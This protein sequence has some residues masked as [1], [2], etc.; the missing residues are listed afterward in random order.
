MIVI[1]NDDFLEKLRRPSNVV[2][3][4]SYTLDYISRS[5]VS[6]STV[7]EFSQ[8]VLSKTNPVLSGDNMI[9]FWD[10]DKYTF[11]IRL[12]FPDNIAFNPQTKEIVVK[13]TGGRDIS[14]SVI[15]FNEIRFYEDNGDL[16][17]VI[18]NN[19]QMD[20]LNSLLGQTRNL[21][22]IKFLDDSVAT[23][24][25]AKENNDFVF[26]S[27]RGVDLGENLFKVDKEGNIMITNDSYF[28]AFSLR[29]SS[30][31]VEA[32]P[33]VRN[34]APYIDMLGKKNSNDYTYRIYKNLSI[35]CSGLEHDCWVPTK[36]NLYRNYEDYY[37]KDSGIRIYGTADYDEYRVFGEEHNRVASG[38]ET[39][40]SIPGIE[41]EE[42]KNTGLIYT[43]DYNKQK[44]LYTKPDGDE[45][46]VNMNASV[47]LRAKLRNYNGEEIVSSQ[48][49]FFQGG[50]EDEWKLESKSTEYYEP[51]DKENI[52]VFL[53]QYDAGMFYTTK[54]SKKKDK[55][56]HHMKITTSLDI[57]KKTDITI[58]FENSLISKYFEV[59]WS[60]KRLYD[61]LDPTVFKK[62]E[63]YV[64][65][66]AKK[67][68]TDPV[69]WWPLNS[70]GVSTL[71]MATLKYDRYTIS[72][73][74]IQGPRVK[75]LKLYEFNP[76]GANFSE[77]R[78]IEFSA[79]EKTKTYWMMTEEKVIPSV[80]NWWKAT[81][82]KEE[83]TN[84]KLGISIKSEQYLGRDTYVTGKQDEIV[85]YP[86][87]GESERIGYGLFSEVS[88]MAMRADVETGTNT[89]SYLVSHDDEEIFPENKYLSILDEFSIDEN[90]YITLGTSKIVSQDG[91]VQ[92][93]FN[94]GLTSKI[95]GSFTELNSIPVTKSITTYINNT[96][97]GTTSD[98][99]AES[100]KVDNLK[101]NK[102]YT[103]TNATVPKSISTTTSTDSRLMNSEF[104]LGKGASKYW[105]SDSKVLGQF[106]SDTKDLKASDV[107]SAVGGSLLDKEY[108]SSRYYDTREKQD[109]AISYIAPD[110]SISYTSKE[111]GTSVKVV[112]D[113]EGKLIK[114]PRKIWNNMKLRPVIIDFTTSPKDVND[115]NGDP[116]TFFRVSKDELALDFNT[117][118][119][120]NM[121]T[122]AQVT[123]EISKKGQDP[124]IQI[125]EE[126]K[127]LD[128]KAWRFRNGRIEK[129]IQR[130]SSINI[131][132]TYIDRKRFLVRSNCPFKLTFKYNTG[133][134]NTLA[135][136]K[137]TSFMKEYTISN[138]SQTLYS[139]KYS[140]SYG[141]GIYMNILEADITGAIGEITATYN[142]YST[143]ST[144]N[145]KSFTGYD[146][147]KLVDKNGNI[148]T[149]ELSKLILINKGVAKN[150]FV[151]SRRTLHNIYTDV[152]TD[153]ESTGD[154][155]VITTKDHIREAIA[156]KP[157]SSLKPHLNISAASPNFDV[158]GYVNHQ[159]TLDIERT[160]GAATYFPLNPLGL[161]S[162]LPYNS[163]R[164]YSADSSNGVKYYLYE[165]GIAP[166]ITIQSYPGVLGGN[167]VDYTIPQDLYKTATISGTKYNLATW[168]TD[169]LDLREVSNSRVPVRWVSTNTSATT[170][171]TLPGVSRGSSV[172]YQ[173]KTTEGLDDPLYTCIENPIY[174][175]K[176][177]MSNVT[178]N[179]SFRAIS[180]GTRKVA[181]DITIVQTDKNI[182]YIL[183]EHYIGSSGGDLTT[184]SALFKV[185]HDSYNEYWEK[186]SDSTITEN[187]ANIVLADMSSISKNNL[188]ADIGTTVFVKNTKGFGSAILGKN[189][190]S[191]TAAYIRKR[192]EE[193][194]FPRTVTNA[195]D[196]QIAEVGSALLTYYKTIGKT[197]RLAQV[198]VKY[199]KDKSGNYYIQ[200]TR[201]TITKVSFV[202]KKSSVSLENITYSQSSN[203]DSRT[204]FTVTTNYPLQYVKF[205][206]EEGT[207]CDSRDDYIEKS[208][209][210]ITFEGEEYQVW[211]KYEYNSVKEKYIESGYK[212]YLFPEDLS[213][214]D[215][216]KY[217]PSYVIT[218][219][220]DQQYKGEGPEKTFDK[221][222]KSGN[223]IIR[224][225]E[226]GATVYENSGEIYYVT[227]TP[228]KKYELNSILGEKLEEAIKSINIPYSTEAGI[229]NSK[230]RAT[231]GRLYSEMLDID[232][233]VQPVNIDDT[234][235]F[236]IES[237][238]ENALSNGDYEYTFTLAP[239]IEFRQ[240]GKRFCGQVIINSRVR[241]I[242]AT[243]KYVPT[244]IIN[245]YPK[246]LPLYEGGR[247]ISGS[248]RPIYGTTWETN[249]TKKTTT[250]KEAEKY[251]Y[252]YSILPAMQKKIEEIVP[253]DEVRID[254]YQQKKNYVQLYGDRTRKV[255]SGTTRKF[256]TLYEYG[257]K[258]PYKE[259]D[260]ILLSRETIKLK[261]NDTKW[262]G[263]D[264]SSSFIAELNDI[265][266]L[267]HHIPA[268]N[269]DVARV[270]IKGYESSPRYYV[271]DGDTKAWVSLNRPSDDVLNNSDEF[272]KLVGRLEKLGYTCSTTGII[273]SKVHDFRNEYISTLYLK[274]STEI[275][276]SLGKLN[277]LTVGDIYKVTLQD[278]ERDLSP[279]YELLPLDANNN[280]QIQ[281]SNYDPGAANK[282]GQPYALLYFNSIFSSYYPS[283]INTENILAGKIVSNYKNGSIRDNLVN[284]T[285]ELGEWN[286]SSGISSVDEL[287]YFEKGDER[288]VDS[289]GTYYINLFEFGKSQVEVAEFDPENNQYYVRW[290]KMEQVN[291]EYKR[292]D[293]Y[294]LLLPLGIDHD[295]GDSDY[296]GTTVSGNRVSLIYDSDQ[297]RSQQYEVN[298]ISL[299]Y[300]L[301]RD[302][303]YT[304]MSDVDTDVNY[305]MDTKGKMLVSY[306]KSKKKLYGTSENSLKY[307]WKTL[308][309]KLYQE[310]VS[311]IQPG[312]D[313]GLACASSSMPAKL[314][315]SNSSKN[316]IYENVSGNSTFIDL[317]A[318]EY[319]LTS[320]TLENDVI[321]YGD[322]FHKEG[323][324]E[325]PTTSVA[326][327][328]EYYERV[329]EDSETRK[330]EKKMTIDGIDY[331]VWQKYEYSHS[332]GGMESTNYYILLNKKYDN[333]VT[334]T[335]T[336]D[337]VEKEV[338][339]KYISQLNIDNP[340]SKLKTLYPDYK[341]TLDD[342]GDI[343][344]NT[345]ED[346]PLVDY[347]I[348]DEKERL[349]HSGVINY[350]KWI[351]Y[352][353]GGRK[354][355][356]YYVLIDQSTDYSLIS[357]RQ[358]KKA[359]YT[360]KM[361]GD[362]SEN[363]F[364]ERGDIF[365]KYEYSLD[366]YIEI[367]DEKV[368]YNNITYMKWYKYEYNPSKRRFEKN[369][370][371]YYLINKE[372]GP[373]RQPGGYYVVDYVVT[374][375]GDHIYD[376][377]AE[378]KYFDEAFLDGDNKIYKIY[379]KGAI[380]NEILYKTEASS[381][382]ATGKTD[383]SVSCVDTIT[384][385]WSFEILK[386]SCY[387]DYEGS[388]NNNIRI[389]FPKNT[390]ENDV[391]RKFKIETKEDTGNVRHS[392]ILQITQSSFLGTVYC[393]DTE[394]DTINFKSD[395]TYIGK[396]TGKVIDG[397]REVD[398]YF[399]F[400][401]DIPSSE[402]EFTIND[403][404]S[405]SVILSMGNDTNSAY[406]VDFK[407]YR[408]SINLG[409]NIKREKV[410]KT[411]TIT[412]YYSVY[413]DNTGILTRK[414]KIIKTVKLVQ[415]YKALYIRNPLYLQKKLAKELSSTSPIPEYLGA[416]GI[417]GSFDVPLL[418]PYDQF[419]ALDSVTGMDYTL[420]LRYEECEPSL[421][422]N[423]DFDPAKQYTR[424]ELLSLLGDSPVS[425]WKWSIISPNTVPSKVFEEVDD[426]S[427]FGVSIEQSQEGLQTPCVIY[428]YDSNNTFLTT[429]VTSYVEMVITLVNGYTYNFYIY[430]KKTNK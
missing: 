346:Q 286:T 427:K 168:R 407:K 401:T 293:F 178:I 207:T 125:I 14:S 430:M 299:D 33:F 350:D 312:V 113:R 27:G 326:D 179:Q 81:E 383:I 342:D 67:V 416:G 230:D 35:N 216:G 32:I 119:W 202:Y 297:T 47:F 339:V 382:S 304:E 128:T 263:K 422:N 194:T 152:Y 123:Y 395:G 259:D 228:T 77:V 288:E 413:D 349:Y 197:T 157:K 79:I 23:I 206:S 419:R 170:Y 429:S 274:D 223:K 227:E 307:W 75:G 149:S 135:F 266:G 220:S 92:Y 46:T 221:E 323:S 126:Y 160:S 278:Y 313:H 120:R 180:K 363:Y 66:R 154:P 289:T 229:L 362:S 171:Y 329:F 65:L 20:I 425:S 104:E 344:Y 144:I 161:L 72:F 96:K 195:I 232:V 237:I 305:F 380:D 414:F 60:T 393:E 55:Y 379:K 22:N 291:G 253:S 215:D 251:E 391:V 261:C 159:I 174:W 141:R 39:I 142:D 283:R 175:T 353:S 28:K 148:D 377:P 30:F 360:V 105:V 173:D 345:I 184:A 124:F 324:K 164:S 41:F 138:D 106:V 381:F 99:V 308:V 51:V 410:T 146:T 373:V 334:V 240:E 25:T 412:R 314:F 48:I 279:Y 85:R 117:D 24:K 258:Y 267:V 59:E 5:D 325:M 147:A 402:L 411:L 341:V 21:L 262:S 367:S 217:H 241:K 268:Q 91:V 8:K 151:Y 218:I 333:L 54:K 386:D 167:K 176:V 335:V 287:E 70:K 364:N 318:G 219:D 337:N 196:N 82:I 185:S 112:T 97:S 69:K 356:G 186:S 9:G 98:N 162:V 40:D 361:D 103:M 143:T 403:D 340:N 87:E 343:D 358:P 115:L 88:K 140:S 246:V 16:A 238:S 400:D 280:I 370:Y 193:Q 83:S 17:F 273:S 321:D 355:Q 366:D 12:D 210:T 319:E 212:K 423:G 317:M 277:V 11:R 320:K 109:V 252:E 368:T 156:I 145:S 290:Y 389:N 418:V 205:D 95:G 245:A 359:D 34:D 347:K 102:A 392:A 214:G 203:H 354:Y 269:G 129:Y 31:D 255:Y 327:R 310:C 80:Q 163:N 153:S 303:F 100:A 295:G 284:F 331:S 256:S 316:I 26:L 18:I 71:M 62:T 406:G 298:G 243:N 73:Y 405:A 282:S 352:D 271:W 236:I 311:F 49:R 209:D 84:D 166:K 74:M 158:E 387:I 1:Y 231:R 226:T 201:S 394:N 332:T 225:Y 409:K 404:P 336:I 189:D 188:M 242:L 134:E 265:D 420:P 122:R 264:S 118:S 45:T 200:D 64:T 385:S 76:V 330:Q 296:S 328:D 294:R 428:R 43:I 275:L 270:I 110:G 222:I 211:Y 94:K 233:H 224:I 300:P 114:D 390:T 133:F 250:K 315:L 6:S 372:T 348:V 181:S 285:I 19:T 417:V 61:D 101:R 244:D 426:I 7:E 38:T 63:I 306:D 371:K 376:A 13:D 68:N 52:P 127:N 260:S 421:D 248:T 2:T 183:E 3:I 93:D 111:E 56:S 136:D 301:P 29:D 121:V 150:I 239:T 107:T 155:E 53:F 384:K 37:K 281:V 254:I 338:E 374:V 415:G 89:S 322:Y 235:S 108:T 276:K 132:T 169:E 44:L 365:V 172:I 15:S 191:R 199:F 351:K 4:G 58:S 396:Y 187:T 375:D 399:Y 398:N 78:K 357:L 213:R 130:G 388:Y 139:T 198:L 137:I 204:T 50:R 208:T 177:N 292:L 272:N 36:Y 10:K 182:P 192:E 131:D 116:I 397:V 369:N 378:S 57:K 257:E 424:S 86:K 309:P 234:P 165:N 90:G 249:G 408:L 247:Q 42:V 190:K 302:Y